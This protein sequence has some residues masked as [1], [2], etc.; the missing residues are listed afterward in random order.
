MAVTTTTIIRLKQVEGEWLARGIGIMVYKFST[1]IFCCNHFQSRSQ[2]PLERWRH[3]F[4][5]WFSFIIPNL[6]L[7]CVKN[8]TDNHLAKEESREVP[9]SQRAQ[10]SGRSHQHRPPRGYDNQHVHMHGRYLMSTDI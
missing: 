10:P 3:I 8:C 4:S 6:N 5:F 9:S 7:P 2:F 1:T